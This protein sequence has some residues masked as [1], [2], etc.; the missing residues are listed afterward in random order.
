MH[1]L[2]IIRISAE[3]RKI[4]LLIVPAL[5]GEACRAGTKSHP[6][7]MILGENT[8]FLYWIIQ[9]NF[10]LVKIFVFLLLWREEGLL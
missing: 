9:T 5:A 2:H 1:I 3:I 6:C 10:A 4:R 8:Q 7:L